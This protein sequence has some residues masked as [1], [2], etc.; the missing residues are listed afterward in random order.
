[1]KE[2][3]KKNTA[4]K[5][6]NT[7][8][9]NAKEN[10]K[11]ASTNTNKG[12]SK[13][14]AKEAKQNTNK[15]ASNTKQANTKPASKPQAKEAKKNTT[16]ETPKATT[17]KKEASK[18][19]TKEVKKDTTK[20]N[21]KATTNKKEVSKSKSKETKKASK[22]KKDKKAKKE[23]KSSKFIEIIK[24]RWLIQGTTTT[25]LVLAIVAVFIAITVV[26]QSLELAPID[27]SQE[28][29]YTLS[30]EVKE[31]IKNQDIKS[32]VNIY[33]VGTSDDDP[34]LDL[35]KQ[36]KNVNEHIKAEKIDINERVDIATKYEL[37]DNSSQG[38]IVECGDRSKVLTA[39][40]LSTYDSN[41]G[42]TISIA[43][44]KLATSIIAVTTEKLPK[45][46]FLNGYSA[47]SLQMGMSYLNMFLSNEVTE[48]DSFDILSTGK[49]PDD[50]D[51]LV[52]VS[53]NKDFDEVAKNAI[54]DY[55]YQ[56]K[57]ILW[58]NGATGQ[59]TETPNINEI[60]AEYGVEPFSVGAI[61]ETDSTKMITDGT[62]SVPDIIMPNVMPATP[63]KNATS[64]LMINPTKLNIIEDSD[65]LEELKVK[66]TTLLQAS[67]GSYFRSNFANTVNNITEGDEKGPF[68]IG[69]EL[70]KTVQEGNSDEGKPEKKS[71][72]ILYGES[73]F[74]TD[75]PLF[76]S[77]QAGAITYAYNKVL[78][79]DSIAYLV[80]REE[81]IT[82]RK[83]TGT[84]TYTATEQ[85]NAIIMAV[86]F[87][88]PVL[89]IIIGIVV[90]QVRR[91]K[92]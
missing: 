83:S 28:Q 3:N 49:V 45:V 86:I 58:F 46:Y 12:A 26:L 21:S 48:V 6:S 61:R 90:W 30:D 67:E 38:I 14:Q 39:Q 76:S 63:T 15:K 7:K 81:D 62:N 51:T 20:E 53:P 2:E 55:I 54:K 70:D 78:A 37:T 71:K 73:Q 65:K 59:K 66:S 41:S 85:Q 79:T 92:K 27:L 87:G 75:M 82:S 77:S 16:K 52:I 68:T 4:K 91:R 50:C 23:K 56:G 42:E 84:V 11:K 74:I 13:P 32:D 25:I 34:N 9:T 31:K 8:Q 35:A 57:N 19:Q 89:I 80:D 18:S 33:F 17:N 64:L 72:L 22:N 69:A 5:A 10:E 43:D 47:Y 36:F 88:V 40:D 60:L 24:K 29:L 1:M 44:E